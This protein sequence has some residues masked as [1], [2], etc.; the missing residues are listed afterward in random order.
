M[1]LHLQGGGNVFA[2]MWVHL[3]ICVFRGW[4]FRQASRE[5]WLLALD[6]PPLPDHGGGCRYSKICFPSPCPL[7]AT[8]SRKEKKKEKAD[9]V[10]LGKDKTDKCLMG[11]RTL[12]KNAF[13]SFHLRRCWL[14]R[15]I[16]TLIFSIRLHF[17]K[18]DSRSNSEWLSY[19]V[20]KIPWRREWQPTPVFF[21]GESHGQRSLVGY[22]PW[23]HKEL[24]MT[25]RLT[26]SPCWD[27]P[28]V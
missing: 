9:G 16:G 24:D 5:I 3:S 17:L 2:C 1:P 8:L 28:V 18:Q 12:E 13:S 25:E 20:R 27:G 7:P 21:P 26:V 14:H 22:R 10:N 4:W 19:W 11:G 6:F 15:W 23:G